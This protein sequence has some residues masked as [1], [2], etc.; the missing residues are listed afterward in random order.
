MKG[1]LYTVLA[2]WLP[3]G[4]YPSSLVAVATYPPFLGY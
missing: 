4:R 2:R 3:P 1:S